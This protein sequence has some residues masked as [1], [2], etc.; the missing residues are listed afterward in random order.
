MGGCTEMK[1]SRDAIISI[2]LDVCAE[3]AN[4]TAIVYKAN[5]NFRTVNPYIEL[6]TNNGMIHTRIENKLKVYETTTRGLSLL[7]NFRLIQSELS[8]A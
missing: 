1:R 3:G 8:V 5:L 2:I 4:K 7:D 6:L